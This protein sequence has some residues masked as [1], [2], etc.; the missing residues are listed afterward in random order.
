MRI[1]QDLQLL[2][3]LPLAGNGP[4]RRP[5]M[6]SRSGGPVRSPVAKRKAVLVGV[7][8]ARKVRKARLCST[9]ATTDLLLCPTTPQTLSI[10]RARQDDGPQF[11]LNPFAFNSLSILMN[12]QD[13]WR[14]NPC[15]DNVDFAQFRG[16]GGPSRAPQSA[17]RGRNISRS[18][19]I[20]K[21]APQR[22]NSAAAAA[23]D[24]IWVILLMIEDE[25][26]RAAH[27]HFHLLHPSPHTVVDYLKLYR[28]ARFSDHL[29]GKWVLNNGMYGKLREFVPSK[30]V[31]TSFAGS[32]VASPQ[33]TTVGGKEGSS[34][35]M[36]LVQDVLRNRG[37]FS[38]S[39]S[40]SNKSVK[41]PCVVDMESKL[42]GGSRNI[43]FSPISNQDIDKDFASAISASASTSPVP[44]RSNGGTEEGLSNCQH[45]QQSR[46]DSSP[47]S[48][49][50]TSSSAAHFA[51]RSAE[52]A[53]REAQRNLVSSVAARM[54]MNSS[55]TT[56][57]LN[58]NTIYQEPCLSA[59]SGSNKSLSSRTGRSPSSDRLL[60][61]PNSANRLNHSGS[62]KSDV[63]YSNGQANAIRIAGGHVVVSLC[64]DILWLFSP[65]C[66][67][68]WMC[69]FRL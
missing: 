50:S 59:R 36:K 63:G 26:A 21:S 49:K 2:Q 43:A 9:R 54:N 65:C 6:E 42:E 51:R 11:L 57:S 37:Q 7:L 22:G 55:N 41:S 3:L 39:G 32:G 38:P 15:C 23:T 17:P 28:S 60:Q 35:K 44:V 10:A 4:S 13:D 68:Y 46:A 24:S 12:N 47:N 53:E 16:S 67:D 69:Q 30:F 64:K 48:T 52:K 8:A 20:S 62:R 5:R 14:R 19:S 34:S 1:K 40:P 31:K 27:S 25:F 61:R 58:D 56:I 29:I 33:K 66:F 18:E 45:I